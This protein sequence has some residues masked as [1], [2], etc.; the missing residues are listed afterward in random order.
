MYE[1]VLLYYIEARYVLKEMLK[2]Y[3]LKESLCIYY[4]TK[5]DIMEIRRFYLSNILTKEA[6]FFL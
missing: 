3:E 4:T 5:D 1:E 6:H 2:I